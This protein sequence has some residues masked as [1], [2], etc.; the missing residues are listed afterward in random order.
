LESFL[1]DKREQYDFIHLS[2]VIEP[3]PNYSLFWA[4]DALYWELQ[5]GGSVLLRTPNMEAP[6]ANSSLYATLSHEYG[7]AGSNLVSLLDICGFA[8]VRL[9]DFEDYAPALKRRLGN[10][11]RWPI[12]LQNR[13]GSFVCCAP[14]AVSLGRS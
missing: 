11:L 10:L 1:S 12:L 5:R 8:E 6:C 14:G 13:W 3:V 2:H 4:L 7:F 9:I